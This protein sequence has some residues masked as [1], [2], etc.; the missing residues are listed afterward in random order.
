MQLLVLV[1]TIAPR[2]GY[3]LNHVL[4]TM[5]G[6]KVEL[7][8]DE[9]A[10]NSSI[11]PKIAYSSH[12]VESAIQIYPHVIMQQKGI[13]VQGIQV[14]QW[15]G[16]PIFFQTN[17]SAII[18][19]DIFAAS[20]YL[21]SRYEEYLPFKADPHGRFPSGSSLAVKNNFLHLPLVDLWADELGKILTNNFPNIRVLKRKFEYVPTIDIDNAFAYKHKGLLRN[22][23]GVANSLVHFKFADAFR[24]LLVCFRL[25][26]DPFD[27][28]ETLLS[29]LPSNAVWFVLGGNFSK[30]DRNISVSHRVLQ[31]KLGKI[32]ARHTIGLHPSY[33]SF[34]NFEKLM[35]EKKRLEESI[36]SSVE[37]SRQHFLRMQFPKTNQLLAQAK[38]KFDYSM[39]YPDAIGFRA[40][41]CTAYNF[42]DI[43]D[44][45]ALSLKIIPFQVMDRALL[46]GLKLN[47]EQA[48]EQTLAMAK[49]VK[50]VK[51]TFVTVWHNETLS[52]INEWK[53]WGNVLR[54]ILEKIDS[55]I[56]Q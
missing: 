28:Y 34:N 55:G 15:R 10:F 39:G 16:L 18:P 53:G 35:S 45:K 48:V 49:M 11:L 7:T 6:F 21:I 46:Q 52:G 44:E 32:S 33:S 22:K 26:P 20:F 41:T 38:I 2:I 36:H 12:K 31:E 51:G 14:S 17:A 1:D 56:V 42:Y 50:S 24:R 47:P 43:V 13:S 27:T 23:L 37:H 5:L 8:T 25:K 9:A 3:I 4:G 19:F 30:F 40:S 54:D 29:F